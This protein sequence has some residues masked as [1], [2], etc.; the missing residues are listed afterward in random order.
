[1]DVAAPIKLAMIAPIAFVDPTVAVSTLNVSP[2]IVTI[3]PPLSVI[4]CTPVTTKTPVAS[5]VKVCVPRTRLPSV[6]R[7]AVCVPMTTLPCGF[8]VSVCTSGMGI[9]VGEGEA[10]G[11]LM[12]EFCALLVVV[13]CPFMVSVSPP[14]RVVDG[15]N[16]EGSPLIDDVEVGVFVFGLELPLNTGQG[17]ELDC[18]SGCGVGGGDTG[19]VGAGVG[20][21]PGVVGMFPGAAGLGVGVD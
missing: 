2:E 19:G 20:V 14:C 3:C 9:G 7:D 10:P 4:V 17:E 5:G 18:F 13:V 15:M 8:V 11:E 6:L 12:R 1:V 21:G 16:I